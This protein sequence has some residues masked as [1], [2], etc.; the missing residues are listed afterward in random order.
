MSRKRKI[1]WGILIPF[2]VI[3]LLGLFTLAGIGE[4]FYY[5]KRQLVWHILGLATFL[6]SLRFV[7][8]KTL[9]EWTVTIFIFTFIVLVLVL[10]AGKASKGAQRWIALGPFRF[11]PSEFAKIAFALVMAQ[12]FQWLTDKN[13]LPLGITECLIV[14]LVALPV[15]LAVL[16]QPD[17][18]TSFIFILMALTACLVAG[19]RKRVIILAL[20]LSIGVSYLGWNHVLK[21]YQKNRIRAFLNPKKYRTSIGYHVIQSRIA[22]GSGRLTGKGFMKATQAK[23]GFMPEKHTDFI[24]STYAET[25]GFLGSSVLIFLYIML[26]TRIAELAQRSPNI[27]SLFGIIELGSIFYWHALINLGMTMGVLPVVGVPLPLMSYGGSAILASYINMAC[28]L[29]LAKEH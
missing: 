11:Q 13:K 12:V 8:S 26:F 18:G 20:V 27:Y 29:I 24:F 4:G 9:K 19:L 10:V 16:V 17:L 28:I 15:F 14:F 21:E 22:I 5:F 3:S 2:F 7:D 6:G 23:L 25:T 1:D